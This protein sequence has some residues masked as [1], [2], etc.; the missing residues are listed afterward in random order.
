MD[1]Q[2]ARNVRRL[3][4]KLGVLCV[5]AV[6]VYGS[7]YGKQPRSRERPRPVTPAQVRHVQEMLDK[8]RSGGL[9][10]DEMVGSSPQGATTGR[11]EGSE[12]A[13]TDPIRTRVFAIVAEQ[14]MV[15]VSQIDDHT[16]FSDDLMAD[17]LDIL[18]VLSD[19]KEAFGVGFSLE[20]TEG[21]QTVGDAVDHVTSGRTAS[22]ARPNRSSTSPSEDAAMTSVKS[23]QLACPKCSHET[24]VPVYGSVNVTLYPELKDRLLSRELTRFTC[25][26]CGFACQLAYPMLYHDMESRLAIQMI[27][28]DGPLPGMQG[29]AF[30]KDYRLRRVRSLSAL[31]EKVLVFGG[32]YDDRQVELIKYGICLYLAANFSDTLGNLGALPLDPEKL[33][34]VETS[35]ANT[36]K[37]LMHFVFLVDGSPTGM[38]NVSADEA[39]ALEVGK[40][41]LARV[42][43][44]EQDAQGWREITVWWARDTVGDEQTPIE[45]EVTITPAY[46]LGNPVTKG[47]MQDQLAK[48]AAQDG[49]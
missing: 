21:I 38:L 49:S 7:Y 23:Q 16:R 46:V 45:A 14:M 15:E 42:A 27:P 48:Q 8:H 37:R 43:G 28:V 12:K 1:E 31:N 26:E 47:L 2:T 29:P 24:E 10:I 40:S 19:L 4:V 13:P 36:G 25:G 34:F 11:P 5:V 32:G 22:R 41:Q 33:L 20:D 44:D 9:S 35:P 39:E 3:L 6:I 17:R 30:G 18:V